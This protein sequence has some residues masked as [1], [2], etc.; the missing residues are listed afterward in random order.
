MAQRCHAATSVSSANGRVGSRGGGFPR[1]TSVEAR[2]TLAV[3]ARLFRRRPSRR[4]VSMQ[5]A[6]DLLRRCA[7]CREGPRTVVLAATDPANPYG[8]I[9]GWPELAR[10]ARATVLRSGGG[11][12]ATRRGRAR[13][14]W[15]TG[16]VICGAGA[17]SVALMPSRAAA[18]T[19]GRE[20]ARVV[21]RRLRWEGP[22]AGC[23]S[24]DPTRAAT[25]HRQRGCSRGGLR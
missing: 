18:L 6:L 5:S 23:S 4:A 14:P 19:I 12:P 3:S 7:K 9:I 11:G 20:A 10:Q 1:C 13:H 17:R 15:T 2:R 8:S 24:P 21:P 25:A 16:G 22:G